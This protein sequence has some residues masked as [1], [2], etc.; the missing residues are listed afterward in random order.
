MTRQ[1]R[2]FYWVGYEN[3]NTTL[4][5]DTAPLYVPIVYYRRFN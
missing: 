3:R 5:N 1:V 2:V 4:Q